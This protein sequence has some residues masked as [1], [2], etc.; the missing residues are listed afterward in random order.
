MNKENKE[1]EEELEDP[2]RLRRGLSLEE[3]LRI[4]ASQRWRFEDLLD[5]Y[6]DENQRTGKRRRVFGAYHASEVPR[7]LRMVYYM[8]REPGAAEPATRE[9]QRRWAA[10]NLAHA[11][12]KLVLDWAGLLVHNEQAISVYD[13]ENDIAIVGRL[14]D[15]IQMASE[16]G[17]VVIEVKSVSRMPNIKEPNP[18]HVMQLTPYLQ[19]VQSGQ[20]YVV[21]ISRQNYE[22]RTF[23]VTYDR[24]ILQEAMMRARA[25]H[26]AVGTGT[27][28][29]PEAKLVAARRHEC[30]YCR[31]RRR[32]D[33]DGYTP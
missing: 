31:F 25:I 10:G 32:C 33:E 1:K 2:H 14:D 29:P 22:T 11:F 30:R 26:G 27:P 6:L 23:P 19:A 20:G 17:P 18:Q 16:K 24:E 12:V 5:Q 8:Y 7:C 3:R 15:H 9:D 13:V 28:P 4:A 21:Y